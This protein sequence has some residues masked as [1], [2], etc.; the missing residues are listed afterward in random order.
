MPRPWT[1][2]DTNI[3]VK[4]PELPCLDSS[5]LDQAARVEA[6]SGIRAGN[7]PGS[8]RRS[9]RQT[10]GFA[11]GRAA[12]MGRG[13]RPNDQTGPQGTAPEPVLCLF[14]GNR[15]AV[16]SEPPAD[17]SLLNSGPRRLRP[18]VIALAPVG[19]P[20]DGKA[21]GLGS[22]TRPAPPSCPRVEAID[23]GRPST[24]SSP[25]IPPY[26]PPDGSPGRGHRPRPSLDPP[27]SHS[28]R[29]SGPPVRVRQFAFPR[30]ARPFCL[31]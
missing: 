19:S 5:R 13:T 6:S 25:P 21:P 7:W 11:P 23:R 8:P 2:A 1:S 22:P 27:L 29:S 30:T 28:P 9:H 18:A 16:L 10:A 31:N 24:R 4:R 26:P 14:R 12:G 17:I 3:V 20:P 15:L